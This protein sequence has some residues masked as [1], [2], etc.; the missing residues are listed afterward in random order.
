MKSAN[1]QD[2]SSAANRLT[3]VRTHSLLLDEPL[4]Y[5]I[6][7][8]VSGKLTH[9]RK[10]G[11]TITAERIAELEK[12]GVKEVLI[13]REFKSS[14][15]DKLLDAIRRPGIE[16]E[17]KG[18]LLKEFAYF[19]LE[20]L[21]STKS[22]TIVLDESKVLVKEIVDFV[23]S[24][25]RS[26]NSI[27]SL[28]VHDIYTYNHSINVSAYAIALGRKVLG[29]DKKGLAEI[30]LAGLLHDLGKKNIPVELINKEDALSREEWEEIRRHPEYG[31]EL[32]EGNSSI[33]TDCRR[34]IYEHH[35][36]FDGSGYPD[37]LSGNEIGRYSRIVAIADVFDALTTNRFHRKLCTV[38]EALTAMTNMQPGKFDPDIFKSLDARFQK[39]TPLLLDKSFDPC[40]PQHLHLPPP[41]KFSLKR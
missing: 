19:Q 11:D 20:E 30:G 16:R 38:E 25:L 21:F 35:E 17:H 23:S 9:F 24:D 15:R 13:P 27:L 14:H 37:G 33:T 40:Q 26:L 29:E 5:D 34:V 12:H 8:I 6:F 39:R 28:S 22:L 4:P 2:T 3:G 32:T 41:P 31:K 18:R 7:L 36:N 10:A 1:A